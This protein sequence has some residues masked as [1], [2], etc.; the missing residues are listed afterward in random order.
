MGRR[1]NAW[2][3]GS[4]DPRTGRPGTIESPGAEV[5]FELTRSLVATDRQRN[6]QGADAYA[7]DVVHGNAK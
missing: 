6:L 5:L 3:W 2:K 1:W 7:K 4:G